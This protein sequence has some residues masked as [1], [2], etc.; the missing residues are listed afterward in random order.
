[1]REKDY[2]IWQTWSWA[3]VAEEVRALAC[4]LAALG[5]KRGHNL[6]I[7]GDNR[8]RL[9]WAMAAAQAL[10]SVPVPLY[11]DAVAEEMIY[12][13]N[14][15][16]VHFA[17]VEDQEQVDKLLEVRER[18]PQ[19]EE[20]IYDDPR[21]LRHY[22]Q[23]FLHSYDEIQ[24]LGRTHHDAHPEFFLEAVAETQPD[25]VSIMLYTSGTT[26]KPKG[27]CQTHRAFI[28]SARGG[29]GFDKLGP[30][31]DVLSY[32]P[33]AW[34]GDHLFSYAQAWSPGFTINCPESAD[35]VMLDLREIGP[36]FYFAPP[37]IYE[38]LLTQVMIRMEDAGAVKRKLFPL[39]HGRRAAL[40]RRHTRRQARIRRG[41]RAVRAR[42]PVR[43]WAA[44]Q[45][46]R[47][48]PHPRRL[49]G[50]RGDRPGPVPLLPLDRHQPEAALRLD[51]DLRLRLPS[52]RRRG[53][54]R[55]RRP[56]GAGRRNQDRRRRRGAG[57][58][59]DA[60]QGILQK[61][62]GDGRHQDRRRLGA[63]RRCRLLRPATA[64]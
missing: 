42:Q 31:D 36:T 11:Q 58:R 41:P 49:Y 53:Q 8:P 39:L 14:D 28:E 40:R 10:G 7:I 33:M 54:V 46:A 48:E 35:T 13:L 26:G 55:H 29:C 52:A 20:I 9:Y 4:G 43:V 2:G 21:G 62:S 3:Q 50:G 17:V 44:A 24:A 19:L 32:L 37:R 18:C 57:A 12:I 63:H 6:A 60:A 51:R 56:G 22:K 15:A 61:R 59:S 27:V 34:V 23:P 25:D 5:F 1:M 30:D 47:H 45:R 64:T 38:N 16:D